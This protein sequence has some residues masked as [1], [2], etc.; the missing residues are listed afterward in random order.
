VNA[1]A[2][3]GVRTSIEAPMMSALAVARQAPLLQAIVPRPAEADDI[4]AAVAFLASDEARN[5][6][7]AVLASD[8][9]WS[10]L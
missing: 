8:G 7:G 10:A 1:I 4:A 5:I 9:G 6:N 3:G 2:P